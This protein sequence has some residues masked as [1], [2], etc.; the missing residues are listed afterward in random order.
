M[1]FSKP[2]REGKALLGAGDDAAHG[3]PWT[4]AL[5]I[6]GVCALCFAAVALGFETGSRG[7]GTAL[8]EPDRSKY[9]QIAGS[10]YT[11]YCDNWEGHENFCQPNGECGTC[12]RPPDTTAN[13]VSMTVKSN[14]TSLQGTY[15]PDGAIPNKYTSDGYMF[16]WDE[17]GG[18]SIPPQGSIEMYFECTKGDTLAY[19]SVE[20]DQGGDIVCY[21]TVQ[22]SCN[23][24]SYWCYNKSKKSHHHLYVN[25]FACSTTCKNSDDTCD[26][27]YCQGYNPMG[28]VCPT[29]S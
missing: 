18:P 23:E 7:L 27:A 8:W 24:V 19:L 4:C 28:M 1:F 3:S 29:C 17:Y 12:T 14:T 16:N 10:P 20:L 13:P 5:K 22:G 6:F 21:E 15:Y 25:Q 11:Y 2:G 26:F 9:P